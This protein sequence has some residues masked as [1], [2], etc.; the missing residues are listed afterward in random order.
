[1]DPAI[2]GALSALAGSLFGSSA[3]IA[4]TWLTQQSASQ[5]ERLAAQL[6]RREGLYSEFINEC[7]KLIMDS[8]D[9]TLDHPEIMASAYSLFNRIRLVASAPVVAAAEAV[10]HSLVESY[11]RKNL[12]LDEIKEVAVQRDNG[13]PLA[14]FSIACR[15]ELDSLHV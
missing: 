7:S 4:T 14:V 6:K 10:I 15:E 1:M 2:I 11:F 12:T 8:L 5:R 9:H 3:S 13:R